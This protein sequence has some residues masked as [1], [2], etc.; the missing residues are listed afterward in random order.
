MVSVNTSNN[1]FFLG[2][3]INFNKNCFTNIFMSH[4]IFR[5]FD[6][7]VGCFDVDS[8]TTTLGACFLMKKVIAFNFAVNFWLVFMNSCFS[9]ADNFKR[10]LKD[11]Y[12]RFEFINMSIEGGD[13]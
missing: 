12:E 2:R 1:K 7:V 10:M 4:R 6:W 9:Q 5:D 8:S 13:V 11:C 3:T